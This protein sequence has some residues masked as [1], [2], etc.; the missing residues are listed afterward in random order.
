MADTE[1]DD[2]YDNGDMKITKCEWTINKYCICIQ[3][4]LEYDKPKTAL[5]ELRESALILKNSLPKKQLK[6]SN[7]FENV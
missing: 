1:L 2:L 7:F 5:Y 3:W 4:T 6:I